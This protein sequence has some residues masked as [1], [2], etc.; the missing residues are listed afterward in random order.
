MEFP[1]YLY[2][3]EHGARLFTSEEEVK[4]AGR[5]WADTPAKFE[6]AEPKAE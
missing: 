2:H 5:G 4:A 6:K 1:T 3:K